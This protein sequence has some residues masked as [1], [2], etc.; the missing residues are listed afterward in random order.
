MQ[1]PEKIAAL[2]LGEEYRTDDIG[3][4]NASVL[5]FQ[6]KVLKIQN[7]DAEAANEYQMM[8]WLRGKKFIAALLSMTKFQNNAFGRLFNLHLLY[9]YRQP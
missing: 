6:D 1:F 5:L 8:T 4:S 3:M 7:D 9:S 2:L